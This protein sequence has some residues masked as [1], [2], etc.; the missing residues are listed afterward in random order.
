[1]ALSLLALSPLARPCLADT[2]VDGEYAV[3]VGVAELAGPDLKL[4]ASTL[5][6]DIP[7]RI[8]LGI[9][10][11]STRVLS[12][13]EIEAYRREAYLKALLSKGAELSSE[14][15]KNDLYLFS[16]ESNYDFTLNRMSEQSAIKAKRAAVEKYSRLRPGDISVSPEKGIA[17]K[18]PESAALYPAPEGDLNLYC[19]RNDLDLLVWGRIWEVDSYY[20]CQIFVYSRIQSA[21]I[22]QDDFTVPK[23]SLQPEMKDMAERVSVCLAGRPNN[24]QTILVSPEDADVF[25]DGVFVGTGNASLDFLT[26]GE[27]RVTV[28]C[29]GYVSKDLVLIAAADRAQRYHVDLEVAPAHRILVTS[30]PS[31]A[32][33]YLGGRN[34]GTT[35]LEIDAPTEP[36]TL[37]LKK[38]GFRDVNAVVTPSTQ[39]VSRGLIKDDFKFK[40]LYDKRRVA[41]YTSLGLF[42]TSIPAVMIT[43]SG[44]LSLSE[45]A[46]DNSAASSALS[47]A[48]SA[49]NIAFWSATAL[50]GGLLGNAVIQFI[51]YINMTNY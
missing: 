11:I 28:D 45:A 46:T 13:E 35:P 50:C 1:L 25:I 36:I 44:T 16:S 20:L 26:P 32:T 51:P 5:K 29:D 18:R 22:F 34:L 31:E 24:R 6:R 17:W 41:F 42:V 3:N 8:L 7:Q 47:A 9:H 19:L 27:H 12:P 10:D 43:Y 30:A 21:S 38:E 39:T 37:T 33:V 48:S 23:D 4:D 2:I 40:E 49:W 15:K 14:V